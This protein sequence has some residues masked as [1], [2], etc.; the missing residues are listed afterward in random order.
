MASRLADI[1]KSEIKTGGGLSSALG[2][3]MMEKIDP[4]QIFDQSGLLTAMFPGLKTY[5]ATK[6]TREK[7]DDSSSKQNVSSAALGA[8]LASTNLTAKN[9]MVLPS[10]ARD[11]NLMRQNV[12]KLVKIQGGSPSY[13]SDMFFKRSE[14]RNSLFK[15]ALSKMGGTTIEGKKSLKSLPIFGMSGE[16][17]G[18]TPKGALYVKTVTGEEEESGGLGKLSLLKN[19][20]PLATGIITSPAFIAAAAIGGTALVARYMKQRNDEELKKPENA[21]VPFNV[22]NAA[23]NQ[24]TA[25]AT[26]G[27][28]EGTA[29]V[30]VQ[31]LIEDKLVGAAA[32]SL[33]N[34]IVRGSTLAKVLQVCSESMK[35]K[36]LDMVSANTS[37]E[38]TPAPAIPVPTPEP[39][40]TSVPDTTN[41]MRRSRGYIPPSEAGGGRGFI[42]PELVR[43]GVSENAVLSGTGGT[44]S[45]GSGGMVVTA[46]PSTPE[47]TITSPT[48][49]SLA[50]A[51]NVP[52][53]PIDYKSYSETLGKRESGNNYSAVNSLGYLGKYQFGAPAL[54]DMGLVKS[55]TSMRGL[56]DPKNWNI[57]GGK[58]A[59]LK[60][61]QLQED[62]MKKY[63]LANYKT[64]KRINVLSNNSSASD[65]AGALASSHLLG[66]GGAKDLIVNGKEGKDA[67]GTKASEYL[68][69]GQV[70]QQNI[71]TQVTTLAS[72]TP[73]SAGM[74]LASASTTVS[75][76]AAYRNTLQTPAAPPVV[77]NAGGSGDTKILTTQRATPYDQRFYAGLVQ[78][79]AL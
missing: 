10:M 65:I 17:D 77:V 47:P 34:D 66:P 14:E 52:G 79:A 40:A 35:Q 8:I 5:K 37:P 54:Q 32:D 55:G 19:L 31:R 61:P 20:L 59:F 16:R 50:S 25:I 13:K 39:T 9:T 21:N 63:T 51:T 48:P 78:N 70:S 38:P 23:R 43:G 41:D 71:P 36:Y 33:C 4:R 62:T 45:T 12:A 27:L 44:I 22:Q 53:L 6:A 49:V 11:M 72:A 73:S 64:L 24:N 28:T 1:Y 60:N 42:N 29:D 67:Y 58:Q 69:L 7:D 68:K 57:D 3:S 30:I 56:D 26:G 2:K 46:T 15:S 76:M 18:Q 74:Q 75:D